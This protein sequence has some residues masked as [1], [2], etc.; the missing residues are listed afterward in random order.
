MACEGVQYSRNP[1]ILDITL[2]KGGFYRMANGSF[3]YS[4]VVKEEEIPNG[5]VIIEEDSKGDWAYVILKGK[6]KLTKKTPKGRITIDTL[7]EGAVLG[8]N[9]LFKKP[10][11]TRKLTAIAHGPVRVG[12]LDSARLDNEYETLPAQLKG[13]MKALSTRLETTAERVSLMT[14]QGGGVE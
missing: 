2:T 3:I 7:D 9:E 12:L 11:Q 4:Y 5:E 14:M 6:A 13:L 8:I 10:E 1:C